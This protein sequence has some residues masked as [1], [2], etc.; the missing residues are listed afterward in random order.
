MSDEFVEN[1][2]EY[3]GVRMGM[4]GLR[5]GNEHLSDSENQRTV[6]HFQ[7]V[8]TSDQDDLFYTM[9]DISWAHIHI[10]VS[11]TTISY[12]M[13]VA[14]TIQKQKPSVEY[15]ICLSFHISKI[16]ITLE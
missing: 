11:Y 10:S 1:M 16:S 2:E 6:I 4:D 8:S 12:Q 9:V 7:R 3:F 5:I 15:Q 13:P 14:L